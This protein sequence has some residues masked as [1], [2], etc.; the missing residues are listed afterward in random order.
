MK[1]RNSV[2]KSQFYWEHRNKIN[3]PLL[4]RGKDRSWMDATSALS[5]Y[6]A[7]LTI[8]ATSTSQSSKPSFRTP[9]L[10]FFMS[11]VSCKKNSNKNGKNRHLTSELTYIH[12]FGSG[13]NEYVKLQHYNQQL[14]NKILGP[15]RKIYK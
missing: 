12:Q 4:C 7:D 5:L 1:K 10:I 9:I 8:S 3:L 13:I 2:H 6:A 14:N 11:P 15:N